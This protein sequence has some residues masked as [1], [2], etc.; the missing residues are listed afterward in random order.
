MSRRLFSG[1]TWVGGTTSRPSVCGLIA[2]TFIKL[3]GALSAGFLNKSR[4]SKDIAVFKAPQHGHKCLKGPW[5]SPRSRCAAA[6]FLQFFQ[7]ECPVLRVAQKTA[8]QRMTGIANGH[9]AN[10]QIYQNID[11]GGG[12]QSRQCQ[13]RLVSSEEIEA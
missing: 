13:N 11:E 5:V 8:I 7:V 1:G 3:L 9:I 6:V 4:Y 2:F 10:Q 12:N